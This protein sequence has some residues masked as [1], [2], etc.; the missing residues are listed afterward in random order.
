MGRGVCS[1]AA[2]T[3][4]HMTWPLF[5]YFCLAPSLSC[6]HMP[7]SPPNSKFQAFSPYLT[8]QHRK[9][10]GKGAILNIS[11]T[12]MSDQLSQP[13]LFYTHKNKSCVRGETF[14]VRLYSIYIYYLL[15]ISSFTK[16]YLQ[17]SKSFYKNDYFLCNNIQVKFGFPI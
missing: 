15:L 12:S 8:H 2:F 3:F 17:Q 4:G 9:R 6:L 14:I 1:D 11:M 10:G 7:V 5:A 13:V 16:Q